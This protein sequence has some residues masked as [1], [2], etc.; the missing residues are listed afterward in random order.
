MP[1]GPRG[2]PQ[3]LREDAVSHSLESGRFWRWA[4]LVFGSIVGLAALTVVLAPSPSR[5]ER[6]LDPTPFRSAIET[7]ESVLYAAGRL[8]PDDQMTL[9]EGM[10]EFLLVLRKQLPTVAQRRALEKYERFCTMTPVMAEQS[11]FDLVAARKEWEE[12]RAAH[13]RAAP[14]FRRSSVALEEAQTSGTARGIPADADKYQPAIDQLRLLCS[15]VEAEL[16]AVPDDPEDIDHEAHGRWRTARSD[17]QRDVERLRQQLPVPFAGME[18][19]WRRAWDDLDKAMRGLPGLMRPNLYSPVLMPHGAE[20]RGRIPA[21]RAL[22]DQAQASLD[23]AP[24]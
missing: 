2:C 22:I 14:W 18:P 23:A 12:L 3:C 7:T 4:A 8:G 19:R 20:A 21:G 16:A 1:A 10:G 9:R 13:F 17:V 5:V 24:R 6:V 11:S 15:R